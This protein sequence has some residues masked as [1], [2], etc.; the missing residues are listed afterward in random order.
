M[1]HVT[2]MLGGASV[3]MIQPLNLLF[4][5]PKIRTTIMVLLLQPD[6]GSLDVDDMPVHTFAEVYNWVQEHNDYM[7]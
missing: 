3:L 5:L 7:L 2:Q 4:I 6:N 1:Y